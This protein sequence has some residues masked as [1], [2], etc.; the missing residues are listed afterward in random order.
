LALVS[1]KCTNEYSKDDECGI[2]YDDIS[3]GIDWSVPHGEELVSAKD[4]ELPYL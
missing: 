3:L 4:K 1:Y 2:R